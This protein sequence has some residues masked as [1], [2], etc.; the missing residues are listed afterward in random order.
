MEL[1][2]KSVKNH[3]LSHTNEW[4]FTCSYCSRK[5]AKQEWLVGHIQ[6]VHEVKKGRREEEDDPSL[7]LGP[8]VAVS[9]KR[10]DPPNN[11]KVSL[12]KL[13]SKTLCEICG[14][15]FGNK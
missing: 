12:K 4:K 10:L 3:M 7:E 6:K 15:T 5:F 1:K 11:V 9:E 2:A 13:V 8:A 14:K